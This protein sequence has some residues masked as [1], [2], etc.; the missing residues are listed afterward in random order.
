[1][2]KI[3]PIIIALLV[4]VNLFA[5]VTTSSLVGSVKD[6]K[7]TLI[8]ATVKATHQPTGTVYSSSTRADG[9]FSIQN[10]RVGGPYLIEVSFVGYKR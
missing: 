5:Q 10:M 2:K 1:M 4:S 9:Q 7:E 3:L 6:S 8:G